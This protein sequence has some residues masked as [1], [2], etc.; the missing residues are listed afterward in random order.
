MRYLEIIETGGDVV[1]AMVFETP[2][3]WDNPRGDWDQKEDCYASWFLGHA[4]QAPHADQA[5]PLPPNVAAQFN[6]KPAHWAS[7]QLD[8]EPTEQA[9]IDAWCAERSW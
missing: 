6:S 8:I 3:R 2:V 1:Y 7:V 4:D 9:R 5:I